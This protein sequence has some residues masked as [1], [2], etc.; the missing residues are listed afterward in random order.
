MPSESFDRHILLVI[1]V[2][3]LL[4]DHSTLSD[5]PDK[6]S[7]VDA[8]YLFAQAARPPDW[9]GPVKQPFTLT[10]RAGDTLFFR[11]APV[12]LRGEH[13]LFLQEIRSN[14]TPVMSSPA[15]S[16]RSGAF[17]VRPDF[18]NLLQLESQPADDYHLKSQLSAQ[19]RWPAEIRFIL[20]NPDCS[21][22]GYFSI[23]AE[24]DLQS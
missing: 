9:Q 10:A 1:D 2:E 7:P 15:P 24:F 21:I 23:Q 6:P 11:S 18:D 20:L 4:S 3:S 16:T 13:I 5:S 22:K 8:R 14:A 12:A 19:G 17:I